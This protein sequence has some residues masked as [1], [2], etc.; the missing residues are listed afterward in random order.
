MK[1]FRVE[2]YEMVKCKRV[3]YVNAANK[4]EAYNKWSDEL[5]EYYDE[6]GYDTEVD[7]HLNDICDLGEVDDEE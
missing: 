3:M 7:Y 6:I 1:T 5:S 2:Y 4:D